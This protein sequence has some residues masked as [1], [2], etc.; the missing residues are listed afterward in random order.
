MTERFRQ[1]LHV[2]YGGAHLFKVDTV[3]KVGALAKK[4]FDLYA[5]DPASFARALGLDLTPEVAAD[6]YARVARKLEAEPVEDY[7]IDFED[8]YGPRADD[9]EDGHALG[10]GA[11]L[12]EA[13]RRGSHSRRMGFRIKA[14]GSATRARSLRTLDRFLTAFASEGGGKMPNGFVVTL[15]KVLDPSEV[16]V[17][18][19]ELARLEARLGFPAESVGIEVM[20]EAPRTFFDPEGR[21]VLPAIVAAGEGR[22]VAAHL[23]SYDYTASLGIAAHEQRLMHPACDFAKQLMQLVLADSGVALSDGAT[24]TLPIEPHRAAAGRELTAK[25]HE[26]NRSAVHG[27]W[28]LHANGVRHGLSQ[29]FYQGWDLHPAQ[30]PARYGAVFA[31]FRAAAPAMSARLQAFRAREQQATRVGQAFDDAAT[32]RGL[33]NFMERGVACGAL[34]PEDPREAGSAMSV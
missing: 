15:P 28:K 10:A 6:V 24:A 26:E 1:P 17:L 4:S 29:G 23:G 21:V 18:A 3:R 20:V 30:I 9:E 16:A 31:F 12:A 11:A 34:D 32:A 22:C 2:V 5:P 13:T 27:A 14:M 19:D 33:V 25:E 8:G 7:R